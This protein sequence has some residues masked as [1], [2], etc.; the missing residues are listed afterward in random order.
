MS[1]A[2]AT[3]K[4][5]RTTAGRAGDNRSFFTVLAV[6][7]CGLLLVGALGFGYLR[8][9]SPLALLLGSDR[10]IAAATLYVPTRAPFTFSLLTNPERLSAFQQAVVSP[11]WRQQAINEIAQVQQNIFQATGLDYERD[12]RPWAGEEIT[13]AYTDIDL[14]QAPANGQQP[15]YFLA[16]EIAPNAKRQAQSFLQLFW[17]Q[18]ALAGNQPVSQK[19]SGVRV[20]SG[21]ASNT[22]I[23]AVTALV[24]DRFVI[25]ANDLRV[26]RR[27][28]R[29]AQT[30]Q[31]LAQN[32]AYRQVAEALPRARIGLAY[33]DTALLNLPSQFAAVS[34]GL[35]QT[36]LTVEAK[37]AEGRTAEAYA[38][39]KT[40]LSA[41]SNKDLGSEAV[42]ARTLPTEAMQ[43]LPDSADLALFGDD[44]AMLQ[45]SLLS[46]SL[47]AD[48]LPEFI[49]LGQSLPEN[50]WEQATREYSLARMSGS[51]ISDW[52]LAV[53][54]DVKV[55]SEPAEDKAAITEAAKNTIETTTQA[56]D[57]AAALAG[58]TVVP[59]SIGESEATAWTRFKVSSR[60]R[61]AG[62]GLETELLGLHLQQGDY[63]IY[64]SSLAA[65]NSALA[66]PST[67]LI[68]S[69]GFLQTVAPLESPNDGYIYVDW[70]VV[71]PAIGRLVP[72]FG[73]VDAMAS[74]LT[75]HIRAIAASRQGEN[76]SFS[77]QLK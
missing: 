32:L 68:E 40:L 64:A 50:P 8:T 9:N 53:K 26:I 20:V 46:S 25:F 58:Y 63:D 3:S 39:Q 48:S 55:V 51:R 27:S 13:Y 54:R 23:S 41:G 6:G 42:S 33:F 19:I 34:I 5:K 1:A 67:S 15:G 30:A 44:F 18:Q 73:A 22:D 77:I 43:Y 57:R 75:R 76:A 38:Q 60:R 21:T 12:I 69:P 52:I 62:S 56:L 66:A 24:G 61:Q 35:T 70:P 2:A 28:I 29:A 37:A 47:A 36:G 31:N 4:A 16:I 72:A 17:Q 14:D 59:V 11:E 45:S 74:P 49:Q 7:A 65:M 71:A 10:T